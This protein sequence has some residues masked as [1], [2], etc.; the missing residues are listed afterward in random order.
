MLAAFPLE[1]ATLIAI[2]DA[3]HRAWTSVTA[4]TVPQ[5]APSLPPLRPEWWPFLDCNAPTQPAKP[6]LSDCDSESPPASA[7][8]RVHEPAWGNFLDCSIEVIDA[9]LLVASTNLSEDGTFTLSWVTAPAIDG[10]FG[11]E[12]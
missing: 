11:L 6:M 4:D 10:A 1:E 12:E 3:I 8:K 7:I 5:P 9:P 2:P